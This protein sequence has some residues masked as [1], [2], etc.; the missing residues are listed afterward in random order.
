MYI[1]VIEILQNDKRDVWVTYNSNVITW[2]FI[3]RSVIWNF[4]VYQDYNKEP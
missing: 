4:V 3:V 2:K 1:A